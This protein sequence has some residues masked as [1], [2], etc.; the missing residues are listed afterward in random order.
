M[1]K[2]LSLLLVAAAC[3]S[4]SMIGLD[5]LGEEQTLGGVTSTAGRGY[6]GGAKT[7]DSE[8]LSL[9]NPARAAFDTKVVFNINFLVEMMAAERHGKYFGTRSISIPSFNLSFPMGNFGTMGVSLWQ[10]Y[11]SVFNEEVEDSVSSVNAKMEYQSS[12]YEIVPSYSVR[13]PYIRNVSLGASAHIVMGNSIRSLMLGPDNS[14][15][16]EEDAWATNEAKISDFVGGTWELK[17]HPAYYSFA[18][19]YRGR[20]ASYFF[21]YTM[22]HTLLNKLNYNFR[23]SEID[24]LAP[25][26]ND[27]EIKVPATLATGINLRF[28][29]RNNV[30]MDLQWRAWDEDVENMAGSYSMKNVTETGNDVLASVGFQ[31]D[32][33]PLFYDP[34]WDRITYRVGAWFKQWYVKDVDEVG[35]SLGAGFPLGRK[36]TIVDVALQGGKRF[37]DDDH[38]W[39]ET[40]VGIR[41]G[42]VGIGNWGQSRR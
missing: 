27:R 32:G 11:A 28:K 23:F 18:L 38:N 3:A 1:K 40:F 33:S 24:T 36:G 25:N 12:V 37:V 42:L 13:L 21:S 7:G 31:R 34:Y 16:P 17:N 41:L 35:G 10:S 39:E 22:P 9:T 20:M 26:R 14:E 30:M 4:A 8:G 15:V 29:K 2:I 5:A 19:Q 6:A